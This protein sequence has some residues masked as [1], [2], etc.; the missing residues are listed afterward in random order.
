[1]HAALH[2][3]LSGWDNLQKMPGVRHDWCRHMPWTF[4]SITCIVMQLLLSGQ[5][6]SSIFDCTL[7][8]VY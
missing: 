2:M 8:A 7:I 5:G 4:A 1:M 6:T 3:A